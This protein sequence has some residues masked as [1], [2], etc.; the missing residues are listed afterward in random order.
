MKHH[1]SFTNTHTWKDGEG[2]NNYKTQKIKR[3]EDILNAIGIHIRAS[4]FILL[5][6]SVPS[7]DKIFFQSFQVQPTGNPAHLVY[8]L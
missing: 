2:E 5:Q 1:Y 8:L 7:N 4:G 3:G 6:V